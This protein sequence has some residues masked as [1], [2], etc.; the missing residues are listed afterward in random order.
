MNAIHYGKKTHLRTERAAW[1]NN[2]YESVPF[3]CSAKLSDRT[4]KDQ[5]A[6]AVYKRFKSKSSCSVSEF[7]RETPTSGHVVLLHYYSIGE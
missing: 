6:G 7:V 5:I 2:V 4:V 3:T 1:S